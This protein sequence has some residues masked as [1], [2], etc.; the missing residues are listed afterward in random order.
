M[1]D[2]HVIEGQAERLA[3]VKL[4]Q[5]QREQGIRAQAIKQGRQEREREILESLGKRSLDDIGHMAEVQ[6]A[7]KEE[8][9]R[10]MRMASER[11]MYKGI[12]M[13]LAFAVFVG[14]MS[15][16]GGYWIAREGMF[17]LVAADRARAGANAR[18]AGDALQ[19]YELQAEP[20]DRGAREPGDAP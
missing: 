6:R 4:A 16:M 15:G 13:T 14:M 8:L 9:A 12:A 1:A 10:S 7:H 5:A 17:A 2:P 20:Y 11:A 18:D 19:S 3:K